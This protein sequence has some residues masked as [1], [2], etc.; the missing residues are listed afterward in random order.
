MRA[1]RRARV[2][3]W[4]VKLWADER[5]RTVVVSGVE[6]ALMLFFPLFSFASSAA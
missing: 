6:M 1:R 3:E 4:I 2:K 5:V